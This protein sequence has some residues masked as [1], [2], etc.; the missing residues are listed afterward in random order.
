VD[1]DAAPDARIVPIGPL[2]LDPGVEADAVRTEEAVVLRAGAFVGEQLG[3]LA[4]QIAERLAGL[5]GVQQAKFQKEPLDGVWRRLSH[6]D[7]G[8]QHYCR[9][10][11]HQPPSAGRTGGGADG[12]TSFG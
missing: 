4:G 2:D 12:G 10:K 9:V 1:A 3:H 5:R 11:G 8:S 6:P 7:V